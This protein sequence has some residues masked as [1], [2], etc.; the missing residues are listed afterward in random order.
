MMAQFDPFPMDGESF[1]TP[2][3][4]ECVTEPRTLIFDQFSQT[5]NH[6]RNTGIGTRQTLKPKG[7]L[8][9]VY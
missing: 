8:N 2:E 1:P 3:E 4:S 5:T 9:D 7:Q 6:V